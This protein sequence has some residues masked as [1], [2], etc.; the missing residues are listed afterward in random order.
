VGIV[1]HISQ[2]TKALL[3]VPDDSVISHPLEILQ[4]ELVVVIEY[5][6]LM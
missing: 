5:V 1:G 6:M 2:L 4:V 3:V